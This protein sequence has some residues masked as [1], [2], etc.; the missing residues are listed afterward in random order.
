MTQRKPRQ[1][2]KS[3]FDRILTLLNAKRK[4][5][6]NEEQRESYL[7]IYFQDNALGRF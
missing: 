5:E 2:F 6:N 3:D 4:V 7:S 1:L